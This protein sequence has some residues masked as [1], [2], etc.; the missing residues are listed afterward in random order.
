MTV[1]PDWPWEWWAIIT[2]LLT[3]WILMESAFRLLRSKEPAISHNREDVKPFD[4]E[5]TALSEDVI[6]YIDL[7][8]VHDDPAER[9]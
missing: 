2:L 5:H 1:L 6:R 7:E 3:I 9:R 4:P 8:S